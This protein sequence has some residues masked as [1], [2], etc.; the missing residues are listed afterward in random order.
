MNTFV[1]AATNA[2]DNE[3][4]RT[5][6]GMAARVT[7]ANKV[8]D[9][10]GKIGSARGTTLTPEFQAALSD[11]V[12]LTL[13]VLLWA[14]DVRGGAGERGQF[15]ALL[16]QL[17]KVN[18]ALAGAIMHKI[19]EVGRWDD[20][21][22]YVEPEN[23]KAAL[24]MYASAL[25][26]GNGLAFKWAPREKS[27]RKDEARDL[28]NAMGLSPKHYR[29]FLAMNTN[30]VESQ[31]CAKDWDSINFSHVPS[32]AA[33]RYQ[34]AFDRNASVA[35][36]KYLRELQ[37]PESERDPSVK[38]NAGAVYPYNVVE[39]VQRGKAAIAN[40]QWKA[41]PNYV[42]DAKIL[43]MVDVSGSMGGLGVSY[44]GSPTPMTVAVS[45]GLYLS[46]KN[47]S[48]FKDLFLTFSGSPKFVN[49]KGDL[50]TRMNT[51]RRADWGMNTNVQAAFEKILSMAVSNRVAQEDMPETLLI[52]SDMQ[53]DAATSNG[54]WYRSEKVPAW[55]KTAIQM[56][57]EKYEMA[58]YAMPKI[59]F[60][61]LNAAYGRDNTPVK[62]DENGTALVSG[63]SPAI[64]ESVLADDLEDFTPMSVMLKT[65]MKDRYSY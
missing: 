26:D 2:V 65:I 30:V 38:I 57:R 44:G 32:L 48:S 42:G 22:T 60:W 11:N 43:P 36:A 24:E 5:E 56:M 63:F 14:R 54:G 37:K 20:L 7:T 51:M 8:L 6:N 34:K 4:T 3:M 35:Y 58:G 61:N 52:L 29:K 17:E 39:S 31:M 53:F 18:P 10:F 28:R 49:V 16:A 40:E 27:A 23:R 12:E 47:T 19:P 55:N 15:R 46:E 21:F 50:S 1:N 59:V 41:L 33:A 13:R 9:L 45:L 25:H 62:F 64:M